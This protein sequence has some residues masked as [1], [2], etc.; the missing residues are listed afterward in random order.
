LTGS[1]SNPTSGKIVAPPRAGA[2]KYVISVATRC[3][4]RSMIGS[5]RLN[6]SRSPPGNADAMNISMRHAA[7]RCVNGAG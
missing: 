2:C 1:T 7:A 3:P 5:A 6:W 4:L